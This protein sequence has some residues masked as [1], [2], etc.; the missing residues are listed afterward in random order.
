MQVK[1]ILRNLLPSARAVVLGLLLT[2]CT[3]VDP[4]DL[5]VTALEDPAVARQLLGVHPLSLQWI[6][7]DDFGEARVTRGQGRYYIT[8]EQRDASGN[9]L[10]IDG[11][12]T[13]IS[14]RSLGFVGVIEI[15]VDHLNGGE[16]YRRDG[17]YHFELY[18]DRRFWRLTEMENPDGAVDYVDI[19]FDEAAS[20]AKPVL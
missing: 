4:D 9:Y 11:A 14:T 20:R 18:G 13:R 5:A 7:W 2:A 10:R 6:S 1:G 8:G 15:R 3:I 17:A 16:P 19:Y 12:F